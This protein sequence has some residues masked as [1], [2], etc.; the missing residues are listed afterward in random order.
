MT[1]A[2]GVRQSKGSRAQTILVFLGKEPL[3]CIWGPGAGH[4]LVMKGI[5]PQE[6]L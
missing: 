6:P 1:L 3:G 5:L 4:A 2:P